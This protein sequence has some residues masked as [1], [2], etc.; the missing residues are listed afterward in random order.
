[1]S[2]LKILS[3]GSSYKLKPDAP[4]D[5]VKILS[6]NAIVPLMEKLLADGTIVEYEVDTE[7]V[8]TESPDTFWVFYITPT[9]QGI[10]KADAM[11]RDTIK[12][13]P[14]IGPA[15]DSMVDFTAHRDYLAHT[16]ATYK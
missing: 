12:A 8:H 2:L 10:D 15:F 3:H 9:A 5:A 13:N 1:M 4:D 7:A 11:L 14:L 6:D 16:S